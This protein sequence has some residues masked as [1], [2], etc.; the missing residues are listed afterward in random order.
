M[1]AQLKHGGCWQRCCVMQEQTS[2]FLAAN[3][4]PAA[5]STVEGA[6]THAGAS[7]TPVPAV[8]VGHSMNNQRFHPCAA[9]S[10]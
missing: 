5:Q 8:K 4:G 2:S 7:A 10:S 3:V 6:E 9:L 1:S